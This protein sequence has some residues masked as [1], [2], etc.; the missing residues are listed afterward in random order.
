MCDP[1]VF[2]FGGCVL[3]RQP[4]SSIH[5]LSLTI[6][7][8]PSSQSKGEIKQALDGPLKSENGSYGKF[9]SAK[10]RKKINLASTVFPPLGYIQSK[11]HGLF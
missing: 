5:L 10:K 1:C 8:Q 7:F 3:L 6:L 9:F 2:M 4:L 11:Q